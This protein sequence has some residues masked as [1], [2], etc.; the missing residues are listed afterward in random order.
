MQNL[1]G[2]RDKWLAAVENAGS[3]E[4]LEAIRVDALG[5]KG[6]ISGLMKTLGEL[7]PEQRKEAGQRLN[8]LKDAVSAAIGDRKALL[9]QKALDAKLAAEAIDLTLPARPESDGRL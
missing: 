9:E 7:S 5:K 8:L 2:L 4:T 3:S 1:D 6:E